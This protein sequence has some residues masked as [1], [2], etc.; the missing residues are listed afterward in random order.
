MQLTDA[1]VAGGYTASRRLYDGF[2]LFLLMWP[3]TAGM[4]LLGSTR[5]W[6]YAPGLML[7]FLGSALVWM[8]PL[9]FRETPSWRFPP[10]FGVFALLTVYVI[11]SIFWAVV[12]YAARWEA[13]RWLC[14]LSAAWAW[15]QMAGRTHRWRWLLF[16]LLLSVTLVSLYAVVQEVNNSRLVLW[17]PRPEQYGHRASGTYLC[18]NHLGD[19][20]TMLFPMAILLLFSPVVGFP[21]R[22]MSFYFL[23]VSAPVLYWTQSRS[24]WGGVLAGCCV[25]GL[26]LA[27]RK[28]RGWFLAAMVAL[29]LFAAASGWLAW[30]TLPMVHS[31][32][33]EIVEKRTGAAGVRIPMWKDMPAMICARPVVGYGGGSFIWAYPPYQNHITEHLTWDFLHNEFLQMQVEYG[34]IGSGLLL[35]GLLWGGAGLVLAF[36]RTRSS[37][38]ALLLAGLAGAAASSLIHATVDF[39]FHIFPNPHVLVWLGGVAWGVYFMEDELWLSPSENRWRQGSLVAAGAGA[40]ICLAGAS[41]ALRGGMS[42]VWNLKGEIARTQMDWDAAITDYQCALRWDRGNWQPYLGLGNEYLSQALWYRDPDP[43]AEHAGKQKLASQ[44]EAYLRQAARLNPCD[45][46]VVFSMGRI[47]NVMGDSEGALADY[48]RAAAYQHKHVF[49]RE[50]VGIQL[51]R[52]G[53]DAEAL[54]VFRQNL[55]DGV[56]K[57]ISRLNIQQLERKLATSAP[58]AP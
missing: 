42:Y 44:S 12:P 8:R 52:M 41:L 51:R 55:A 17:A 45:M 46:A 34:A 19:V 37:A 25:T 5:T 2:S 43:A 53:R 32:I 31:R 33:Q 7:S 18:P 3:A 15:T 47:R 27:W 29:P 1:R 24:S 9:V 10:G 13:L 16:V 30:R 54:E 40:L 35:M 23:A 26:L 11:C 20:L 58:P 39:N 22:L 36:H 49:Y 28:G 14:L 38:A 50:Q 4:W 21:L 48:R 57:D 6:G 56:G